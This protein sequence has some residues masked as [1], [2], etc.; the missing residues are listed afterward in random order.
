[1]LPDGVFPASSIISLRVEVYVIPRMEYGTKVACAP[2]GYV[3]FAVLAVTS[4][5]GLLCRSIL[6]VLSR[7][8]QRRSELALHSYVSNVGVV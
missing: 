6:C 2:P 5:G 8:G 1:M 3:V 4:P 7:S